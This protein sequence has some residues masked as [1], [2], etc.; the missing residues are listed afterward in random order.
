M[1]NI[2]TGSYTIYP[3][4]YDVLQGTDKQM[5]LTNCINLM[6]VVVHATSFTLAQLCAVHPCSAA[7]AIS[8]T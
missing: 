8:S 5:F 7:F 4:Q 2:C 1:N 3:L 6:I